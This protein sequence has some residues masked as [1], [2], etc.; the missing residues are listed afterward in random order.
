[1]EFPTSIDQEFDNCETDEV[2]QN[3]SST[4]RTLTLDETSDFKVESTEHGSSSGEKDLD[5]EFVNS[6]QDVVEH[7][8]TTT[9]WSM[10]ET[11][12]FKVETPEAENSSD[13]KDNT[14]QEYRCEDCHKSFRTKN[15]LSRHKKTKHSPSFSCKICDYKTTRKEILWGIYS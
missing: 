12:D 7:T 14:K 9:S 13:E 6:E 3:D 2:E 11:S 4:S 8:G 15:I 1:M 5:E 10:D